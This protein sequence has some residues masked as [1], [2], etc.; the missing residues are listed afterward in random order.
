MR[1]G[2]APSPAGGPAALPDARAWR[3][4]KIPGSKLRAAATLLV[5]A[6]AAAAFLQYGGAGAPQAGAWIVAPS[7]PEWLQMP[8]AIPGGAFAQVQ[9]TA[10]ITTWNA[11]PSPHTISIP[12]EVHPGGTITI[13]WG[14]GNTDDVTANG[15]QSHTYSDSED[16]LVS[17][18]GDLSRINLGIG[19][20]AAS[21]LA[22]IDQWGDIE[23]SSMEQAFKSSFNMV[24]NA[25]DSPDLSGVTSTNQMFSFAV[26]FDG[27]LSEWDT[28]SVTD[29]ANMFESAVLFDG[30]L[31]EWDTSSVTHMS[32]M[33]REAS[34][35]D[36]NL[37]EWD[38]SSVTHM[39]NMFREASAF[40]GNLSKWN[41]SSVTR[42]NGMFNDAT[43]FEQNLGEW[44]VIPADTAYD[45]SEETL[46]VTTISAQNSKL[47][48]HNPNYGIGSGGDSDS[49]NMTG[50][51][52]T[53]KATP[54]TGIYTV[55]VTA[56]GGNFGTG[57][58]H[59][60]LD[61]TVT[62]QGNQPPV[63]TAGGSAS[64]YE[65][66]V[67]RLEGTATDPDAADALTY[68]WTHDGAQSLGITI[69]DDA[70]PSTTFAV[71]G[72]VTSDTQVTF[73]LAVGDGTPPAVTASTDVN[74]L[75]SSGAFIT[76]WEP[77]GSENRVI[78]AVAAPSGAQYV[79]D[80]G[81]GAQSDQDD[82]S[83]GFQSRRYDEA[84]TYRIVIDG[85]IGRV[86]QIDGATTANL[87]K[88]IDQWGDIKWTSMQDAFRRASGM[89]YNATDAPDL[90]GVTDM[91]SMFR[92]ATL[93]DG[94][95]SEWDVSGVTDMT[96]M[97]ANARSFN[98][99]L[100]S[101]N[102]S[103]VTDMN[104]MFHGARSF[105]QLL[106]SWNVSGVTDMSYMFSNT[107][108]DHP[109]NLWNVSGVTD[110][111]SMFEGAIL[112]DQNLGEW[113]V[114]P[115][116][117]A[118][119][120]SEGTL[121]VTTI[122]AQN[123]VLDGHNPNYGIGSGGDSDSFSMTGN[124]L[125]FKATPSAGSYT[126]N[127]TAPGGDFGT[128]NHHRVLDVT[129][130]GQGNQPPTVTG[131]TGATAIDEGMSDTLTGT[132]TDGDGTISSYLWSVD[133]A[134]AVTITSG[135]S[136]TLQYTASQVDSDTPVTFTLTVTDD[137]RAT[138]SLDYPVT[139][140]D[141][142]PLPGTFEAT[143]TPPVSPTNQDPTFG[144]TFGSDVPAGEFAADDVDTSPSGLAVSVSDSGTGF[145]FT[146]N[147]A[148]DGMI[149]AHV[150]AGAV[151]DAGGDSNAASN[152]VS[153]TV[154]KTG[155]QITS[156][157][158]SG[159]D[160]I[161]VSFSEGI[162]GST[163][164]SDWLLQGAP[165]VAVDSA[166]GLPGGSV[167]LGLSED[168][169]E[170]RPELT[171][172]YSGSGIQDLA[173][174]PLGVAADIDVRYQSSGR[175]QGQSAPP[176][177]DIGSVIKSYP[178]SVPE[179]V[180]Q[181]AGARDPGT[182]IPP[183]SVNG[184]FAFPLEM[185]SLGYLLDGSLNTLV[186]HAVAAGQPV[187]IKVTVHDPTPIAYFAVYLNLQ[188]NEISHLQSD[189]QMIW[190][191]GQ[192]RI[193]DPNGLIRNATITISEDPDD[194]AKKTA[195][196]T[197]SFSEEMGMTNMVIRTWN[198]AGQLA[199][200]QIFDAID[201]RAQ[202]PEPVAVDPEPAETE[203]EPVAVD[204]EPAA[205]DDSAERDVLAIR[206]WSGFEP[207]SISDAQLLASLGLDYPGVDIPSWVMTELGP[208]VAKGDI[209]AG[210]FKIALEYVLGNA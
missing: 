189:A 86:F 79:I 35:F 138:A 85:D 56:P 82:F 126:V 177:V 120:I 22:S 51:A 178:Q 210:E 108:F 103:G 78:I 92:G 95:I 29:M 118:Y 107:S 6:A 176:V 91:H 97:F 123:A 115:A 196:L 191:S 202:E 41:V 119:G 163:A 39:S 129:V 47:D 197:A 111:E 148:P 90:S 179:W 87:L 183:I 80:W 60:V 32:N 124:T 4:K 205:V 69:A 10:F 65:G 61:V 17:M 28:S 142:P 9:D 167:T 57:N 33:F 94:D 169:P 25:T 146:I 204:S 53:F 203:P 147:G 31:S 15:T 195:T 7:V 144:V 127:V 72:N 186:P 125:T 166:T 59:R 175:S 190:D 171:L 156:A 141:V 46:S 193:I 152:R 50:N 26:L 160:T 209:T 71:T 109:L 102:V 84:G 40:N 194:P 208:L 48:G 181:A 16:Y 162:R 43:S 113:Y 99:P 161:T 157:R 174:N 52:L 201:V 42:M 18:T 104:S 14:D 180:S 139:V 68:E 105:N 150:P 54:S 2:H 70:A 159:S 19:S 30:N 34:A 75:D 170:D 45:V 36:G 20:T 1:S 110:M 121:S 89:T 5:L 116:D 67:G 11:G 173:G 106:D 187:T 73:T 101:W 128:G 199:T 88:S 206:M 27:N 164:A 62:G 165:G 188:G 63:V 114:I 192:V 83:V 76:T 96:L 21:K 55:N 133:D 185:N 13:D 200:V 207:E 117:T 100:D 184:T 23:W 145:S 198:S 132:A 77:T 49:F 168:L 44:Y 172:D 130:T 182:P 64:A 134:S 143:I 93:F 58:H 137:D 8:D 81:D 24:Y 98:Q 112:F 3:A 158:A 38:T 12:L 66:S 151:S 37:S 122:S 140:R 155:P 131:I 153:V 149:T 136:A 74:I 154:D 135:N